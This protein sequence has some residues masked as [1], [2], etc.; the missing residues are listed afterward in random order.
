MFRPGPCG[1]LMAINRMS[2]IRNITKACIVSILGREIRPHTIFRGLASGYK[3]CVSPAENLAYLV[4]SAEPHLQ[5][6]IRKYVAAGDTV[7]DIGANMGYVSLSLAKRVGP[8]GWVIA[9]EPVPKNLELLRMNVENNHLPNVQVFDVAASD[10]NGK[11]TIRI[12]DSLAMASLVWHK[13]DPAAV[14]LEIGTVAIDDLV[15]AGKFPKPTFIK[16][17]VEGAEGLALQGMSRTVT[18][19][20]PVLFIE[21]SE[22][23][24][25]TTWSILRELGYRCQ[26]AITRKWVERFEEYCHSDF[27]WLPAARTHEND[28]SP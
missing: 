26:E 11:T 16:L 17:D 2:T 8:G 18:A 14:E 13:K 4:G 20:K 1:C 24:R 15:E 27:L 25:Q 9:F 3:I 28:A 6:A 21:C 5:R 12:S 10:R 19:A 23:G 22:T 7:Y